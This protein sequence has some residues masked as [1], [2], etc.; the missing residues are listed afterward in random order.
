MKSGLEGR[1]NMAT[2]QME[3]MCS[4]V[5]MKSGLEGRNNQDGHPI[6]TPSVVESQ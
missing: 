2:E 6:Y 1:N 4:L 5:S 3:V